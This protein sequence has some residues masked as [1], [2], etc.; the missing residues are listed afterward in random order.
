MC[1]YVCVYVCVIS[2]RKLMIHTSIYNELPITSD[3]NTSFI[4]SPSNNSHMSRFIPDI[5]AEKN[6][7][8]TIGELLKTSLYCPH[9]MFS[10]NLNHL[11][12]RCNFTC[13]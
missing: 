6:Q 13:K 5:I 10:K 7:K 4:D 1:L 2:I 11:V 8:T 12:F 9:K 3:T